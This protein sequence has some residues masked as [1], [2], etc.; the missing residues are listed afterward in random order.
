MTDEERAD[1]LAKKV[2]DFLQS[3]V[4]EPSIAMAAMVSAMATLIHFCSKEGQRTPAFGA[5]M[6]DI[7]EAMKFLEVGNNSTL[8]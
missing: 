2:V 1:Q 5:V 4:D 3:E 8:N 6:R 7:A